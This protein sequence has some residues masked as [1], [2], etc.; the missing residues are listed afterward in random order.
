MN[1]PVSLRVVSP[2]SKVIARPASVARGQC[3][4]L[5]KVSED[6]LL[7]INGVVGGY[8]IS[9]DRGET[10]PVQQRSG[11]Y[12]WNN[13]SPLHSPVVENEL[14]LES[15]T[16]NRPAIEWLAGQRFLIMQPEFN[17]RFTTAT[18]SARLGEIRLVT[19]ER[20]YTLDNGDNV[21]ITDT[22]EIG[23]PVLY[24]RNSEDRT[25]VR[26]RTTLQLQ[27]SDR[28]YAFG[29]SIRQSIPEQINGVA[30]TNLTVLERF[31]SY[32]MQ[33]VM[34]VPEPAIWVP[35]CAPIDWG[36]SIRADCRRHDKQWEI[37]QRKSMLPTVG[38]NGWEMPTWC[39]NLVHCATGHF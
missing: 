3:L 15:A 14:Q 24:L 35:V 10:L 23:A 4:S 6:E 8:A 5:G 1:Q 39:S 25:V 12:I 18:H 34:S 16:L 20:R 28:E 38:H 22:R 26:Q 29:E 32:F 27:G 17:V 33:Q 11:Y 19:S 21:A 30:V 13:D 37:V 36:W 9:S 7:D 2:T 31:T